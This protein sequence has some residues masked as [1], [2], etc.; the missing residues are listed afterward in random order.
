[1]QRVAST[2]T[3]APTARRGRRWTVVA[4][5]AAGAMLLGGCGDDDDDGDGSV[6]DDAQRSL[7]SVVTE[8]QDVVDDAGARVAAEAF[9]VAVETDDQAEEDGAA[10]VAVIE[11]NI[12]DLPGSP[13]VAGIA[14]GDGDGVDDDGMI[15]FVIGD[16]ETCVE[17]AADA[18]EVTVL[19]GP[20]P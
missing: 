16:D 1:M 12:G 11:E 8:V 18:A 9:Q 3:S 14:D 5:M 15:A 17:L 6:M 4:V 10:S 19:D 2:M 13:D 20:C 7:E